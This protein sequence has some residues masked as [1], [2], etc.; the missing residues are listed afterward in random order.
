MPLLNDLVPNQSLLCKLW[1]I[2]DSEDI[3]DPNNEL[4]SDD[5]QIFLSRKVNH[6]KSQFLASRKLISLVDPDLRVSYKD[7]VPCL[8]D[9]RNISV[10]YTHL[11]LPTNREV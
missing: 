1:R 3:M 9:N 5:Y 11:T 6:M 10:S 7:D 2:D 8:S 4:N